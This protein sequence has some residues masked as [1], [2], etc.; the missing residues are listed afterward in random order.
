MNIKFSLIFKNVTPTTFFLVGTILSMQDFSFS[1][2][3][4]NSLTHLN[5]GEFKTFISKS[6]LS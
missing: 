5:L 2:F 1:V 4:L 6:G 3:I